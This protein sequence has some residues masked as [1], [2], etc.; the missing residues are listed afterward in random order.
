ANTDLMAGG[1]ASVTVFNPTPGGG[2]SAA[3]TFTINNPVPTVAALNPATATVGGVTFN[4]TVTGTG[5][6]NGSLVRWNGQDRTTT[7]VS[8]TEL[9]AIITA[10]DI[11]VT[12]TAQVT[13]FNPAPGGGA[14]TALPMAINNP[15]PTLAALDPTGA[16][17]G[18]AAFSLKVTGTGFVAASVVRWNGVDRATTFTSATEL[19]AAI[20]AADIANAGSATVLVFNPAPGGGSSGTQSFTIGNPAPAITSLGP[21]TMRAGRPAFT[22]TVTGTGFVAGS[23]VRWNGQDRP[24]QVVAPYALDAWSSSA[25]QLTA[26]ITAADVAAAGTAQV[27][28]FN[29]SPGGGTSTAVAFPITAPIAPLTVDV[30]WEFSCGLTGDG[31]AY[32]WG[33]NVYGQLGTGN[34]ASSATPALVAGGRTYKA[35]TV[36]RRH[37]CA[38]D[39]SGAAWCWGAN[40]GGQLGNGNKTDSNAPV[41]VAGGRT[42][43]AISAGWTH[44][45][46]IT[47][48]GVGYCWGDNGST[49]LGDGTNTER[50]TPTAVYVS[51]AS[52]GAGPMAAIAAGLSH[53]CS[54]NTAGQAW[55]WGMNTGNIG[56]GTLQSRPTP[57]AV[58]GGRT[59]TAITAGSYAT[60][61]VAVGGTG[62]C[63]GGNTAGQLGNGG[64]G[65]A[66][67][68]TAVSGNVTWSRISARTNV[69][70]GV[71]TTGEAYCWGANNGGQLGDGTMTQRLVPTRV[72]GIPAVSAIAAASSGHSC[73]VTAAG[74]AYCWGYNAYGQLGNGARAFPPFP[75]PVVGIPTLTTV[76]TGGDHACGLTAAGAAYC[77]GGGGFGQLGNG[78]FADQFTAVPVAGGLAFKAISPGLDM[79]C[80]LTTA[81]AA[82]C[83]GSNSDGS[84][85]IGST[86][87]NQNQPVAVSGSH[88][89][90]A[91]A[92]GYHY[93]CGVTEVGGE[94]WCWGL[95]TYGKLGDGT[96]TNRY[97]PTRVLGSVVFNSVAANNQHTCGVSTTNAAY[98]WG[99]NGEGQLGNPAAGSSWPNPVGVLG[100]HAF[101]SISVGKQHTCGITTGGALWCWGLDTDGRI[102]DGVVSG[103]RTRPVPIVGGLPFATIAAGDHQTCGT[104]PN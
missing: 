19:R 17:A 61:A 52:A 87:P 11:A 3:K 18:G 12:G 44:S 74:A 22:L 6:S 78:A 84:L 23:V 10:A 4:L 103:P 104:R 98:C 65:S 49:Q 1:T 30:G 51:G 76:A 34:N 47:P 101:A 38:L 62:Y 43:A 33:A 57:V 99:A 80:A 26:N 67:V 71:S 75:T 63:W 95:N 20:S 72:T 68:P 66:L 31:A 90:K 5:F 64:T 56:D 28:V 92:A 45:C 69:A 59:Y 100:G 50:L 58:S 85:G 97:V 82:Y 88:V 2:A 7:F 13:V 70:C 54:L 46:A 39:L 42:F 89:F 9:R 79:T 37:A 32:C 40:G 24:T 35:I 91:I 36:G 48:A 73:A 8:A 60:C 41:A 14:S 21:A 86:G 53:T 15:S 81:G 96:T 25:T 16:I 77:W 102:G 29:P 55:C 27:T 94:T 83:W 93:A